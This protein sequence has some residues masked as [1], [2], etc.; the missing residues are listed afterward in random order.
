MRAQLLE[1]SGTC[2][3]VCRL[4]VL[5]SSEERCADHVFQSIHRPH[6]L[7]FAKPARAVCPTLEEGSIT[8]IEIFI[9]VANALHQDHHLSLRYS[10]SIPSQVV[11]ASPVPVPVPAPEPLP[12]LHHT[13]VHFPVP[14]Y[15]VEFNHSHS[16]NRSNPPPHPLHRPL[17][18]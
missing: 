14:A 5:V 8:V 15:L 3:L 18:P 17:R 10:P 11:K 2:V 4:T 13:Q 6:L 16:M 12:R 7:C 9:R 1:K